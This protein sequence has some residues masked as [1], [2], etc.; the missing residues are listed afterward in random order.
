VWPYQST[1]LVVRVEA[2]SQELSIKNI[3][4]IFNELAVLSDTW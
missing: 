2:L 3:K 4:N 1:A